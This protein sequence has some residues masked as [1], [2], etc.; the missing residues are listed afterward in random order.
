MSRKTKKNLLIVL[1]IALAI[2]V[3]YP[4]RINRY[5]KRK[6]RAHTSAP[7]GTLEGVMFQKIALD[8]EAQGQFTSLVIG[9]DHKLYAGA[10]DGKI[11]RFVIEPS[12]H[13]LLEHT[14]KPYGETSKFTIGLAFDPSSTPDSLIVWTTNSETPSSW[15]V[16]PDIQEQVNTKNW[17]GSMARIH[18][19]STTDQVFKNEQ[20]LKDLPR[21]GPNQENFSNSIAFAPNGKLYF[22]QGANTGMG[23]CDCEP[24]QEPTREALL[25]STILCLDL[26]KLP[27]ELPLSVK[28]VDGGGSYDPYT[29]IAPLKIYATG[30]RN[31]YDLVWHSNGQ[32]YTTINGSGGNENTPTSDPGSPYYVPYYVKIKY[33]GPNNIP[34]VIDAQPDQNDFMARVDQGGYYGHPNPLRAEYVLN[35][36]DDALDNFEYNG[37]APDPN[38]RGFTYDFGP[39]VAPTGVIEYKSEKFN[40]KLK[41]CLI[42]ARMGHDDL[43][44]L[45]PGGEKKD[46]IQ[47]YDGT[48]MDLVLEGG[49]LDLVED[50][51][52]GNIY[53]SGFSNKNITLFL[54][55][56]RES[57][58]LVKNIPKETIAP[59]ENGKAIYEQNCQMCHGEMG[60]GAVGP[61]LID[62]EWIYGKENI[63]FIIK[64]G[65][66]NGSMPPWIDKLKE[67]EIKLV[68]DYIS[69]LK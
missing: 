11:K 34:A 3:F 28:T 56:E 1:S 20:I 59:L 48:I 19:S 18:L 29:A 68:I 49:P 13:L 45:R 24:N 16:F 46:I 21:F 40:G 14:F 8:D 47:D 41:G 69:S 38:F 15:V 43:V 44:L 53:V 54:P 5:F 36:G 35:Q 67:K 26:N 37:I 62:D 9:P 61:S 63:L 51:K 57:D 32:L 23:L 33:T 7:K 17:A 66:I 42:V 27:Q 25:S 4:N 22:A 10:I 65:S 12:G 30:I 58:R 60:Q 2:L 55:I 64:N 50:T 31:G 6:Y 52:T 39:H